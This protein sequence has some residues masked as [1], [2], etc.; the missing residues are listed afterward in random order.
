MQRFYQGQLDFFCAA[1]AVINAMTAMYGI[2]L[3]Q[4]RAL[5]ASALADVSR[6]PV[7][8]Q[9]TLYNETDFHWLADY[10]LFACN[11]SITYPIRVSRPFAELHAIPETA[12]N[13]AEAKP[14]IAPSATSNNP[15]EIWSALENWLPDTPGQPKAGSA[16]R[17]VLLR[18]HRYIRY[19]NKPIVSHWSMMDCHHV[20]IFT[21]RDASKEENALYSIDRDMTVFDERQISEKFPVRIEPNS[22]YFIERR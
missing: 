12:A 13:L 22:L 3:S 6:H 18:F 5:L 9:A 7:L 20:G 4:A 19:V 21:L 10:M 15:D 14:F 16:R 17:V 2:N 1:Y 11:K 8:W